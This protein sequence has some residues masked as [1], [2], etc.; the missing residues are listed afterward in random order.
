MA[1]RGID[2]LPLLDVFMVVLF[3]FATIQEQ[4]LDSSTQE[5]DSAS[6]ALEQRTA[7]LERLAAE[8]AVYERRSAQQTRREQELRELVDEY[9]RVCGSR[10]ANGPLCPAAEAVPDARAQAAMA[11][12]HERLLDNL[13]VFEIELDGR[14]DLEANKLRNLC[15]YR[16]DP[17]Q[18]EWRRCGE[19]PTHEAAMFEWYDDGADGLRDGLSRTR[20]GK[21]IV[22][23]RQSREAR[24]RVSN[25]LAELLRA[26]MKDVRVYDDGVAGG[27][28]QCPLFD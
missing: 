14:P 6:A 26:R 28:L 17:P 18:G 9:E 19:V 11:G 25:D 1:K 3:V 8:H 20:G 22:L 27:P 12:V 7:E 13:A 10:V 2:M 21:A 15:C 23:L 24:M 5:L 4:Q 16:A